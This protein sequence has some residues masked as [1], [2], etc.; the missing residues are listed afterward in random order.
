MNIKFE[1]TCDEIAKADAGLAERTYCPTQLT[2]QGLKRAIVDDHDAFDLSPEAAE[3]FRRRAAIPIGLSERLACDTW[4]AVVNECWQDSTKQ[5]LHAAQAERKSAAPSVKLLILGGCVAGVADGTLPRIS[6]APVIDC[7]RSYLLNAGL[8]DATVRGCHIQRGGAFELNVSFGSICAEPRVGDIVEGGF[9]LTHSPIGDRAT[10]LVIMLYRLACENGAMVP[11]CNGTKRGR[12]RRSSGQPTSAD[13][14]LAQITLLLDEATRQ[15]PQKLE[16]LKTLAKANV[17]CDA[18]TELQTIAQRRRLNRQ[19]TAELVKALDH[20]EGGPAGNTRY[21]VLQ[22]LS[23]VATHGNLSPRLHHEL[24][25]YAGVYSQGDHFR[26]CPFCRSIIQGRL[27][28]E[29][30]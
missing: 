18:A 27:P 23:R 29:R 25:R 14:V 1:Q 17:A 5:E 28:S 24:S 12:T 21:D 9:S 11:V 8:T 22:A 7:V 15:M 26:R 19:V 4:N 6:N 13:A 3:T 2:F 16:Q 20:D 30:N 10:Q